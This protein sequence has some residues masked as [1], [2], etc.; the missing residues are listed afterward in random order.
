VVVGCAPKVVAPSDAPEAGSIEVQQVEPHETFADVAFECGP[1]V[2]GAEA[3]VKPG[4]VVLVGELHGTEQVPALVGALACHAAQQP[5]AKVVLGLEIGADDQA[6]VDAFVASDGGEPAV[7]R[8][9]EASHFASGMKDGRSSQAM[10][11]LLDAIRQWRAQGASIEPV[12]FDAPPGVATSASER[13]A[14]MAR[15]L[16][17]A[18]QA[19]PDAVVLVLTGNIHN[20]TVRGAPWDKDYVPMGA[21]VR[22]AFSETIS[23]DFRGAGGT[24]W[25]CMG[26]PG[27][28]E[29]ER[30]SAKMGGEDRGP[31]PFIELLQERNEYGFD[32]IAYVGPTTASAPAGLPE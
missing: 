14:A 1:P 11:G 32:G 21:H 9:L 17:A 24:A 31:E 2:R 20:R 10:L 7:A 28:G 30:G 12:C 4:A 15:T 25:V 6:A 27:D 23:L 18:R 26:K 16:I 13:D 19:A 22:E 3:I 5:A 29:P 8:L